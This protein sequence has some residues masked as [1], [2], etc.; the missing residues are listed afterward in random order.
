MIALTSKCIRMSCVAGIYICSFVGIADAQIGEEQ[1]RKQARAEAVANLHL[2]A[3]RYL[4][5]QRRED[6][7]QMFGAATGKPPGTIFFYELSSEGDEVRGSTVI[8]HLS[9]D[10]ALN[11]F[12]GVTAANGM[13]FRIGGFGFADS[14]LE[15]N[16]MMAESKFRILSPDHAQ[17]LADLYIAINPEKIEFTLVKSP[18]EVK[19]AVERQCHSLGRDFVFSDKEFTR[20]WNTHRSTILSANLDDKVL[21]SPE[22]FK[23]QFFTLSFPTKQKECG[24]APVTAT[25]Q[26]SATGQVGKLVFTKF[27]GL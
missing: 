20:W 21:P 16:R 8:H 12:I 5:T 26:V 17:A 7:E 2:D 3:T 15:F 6:I 10:A 14:L 23:V 25:L 27:S 1:A 11:L 24:G 19:Q 18:L 22:G 13:V 4:N 9:T